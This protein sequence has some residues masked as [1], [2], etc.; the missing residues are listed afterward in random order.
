MRH[1][2]DVLGYTFTTPDLLTQALTHP[3]A[4]RASVTKSFERLEFLGDRALGLAVAHMVYIHF[5][6]EAEGPLAKRLASLCSKGQL[7]KIAHLWQVADHIIAP[8]L[9]KGADNVLADTVESILGAV[10]LDGGIEPIFQIVKKFWTPYLL[11][12]SGQADAK[13]QLQ[14]WLK[15]KGLEMPVYTL[16]GKEGPDHAPLF[17][18]QVLGKGLTAISQAAT[19]KEAEQLAATFLLAQ[20]E[21]LL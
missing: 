6:N 21:S 15:A 18:V 2:T 3:S 19:K 17:R 13:S 5:P 11:T 1:I 14:M 4:I 8:G 20:L 7:V 12:D 10:F 9:Q 16:L